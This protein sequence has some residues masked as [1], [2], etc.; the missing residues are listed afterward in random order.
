MHNIDI[1]D[2]NCL[3]RTLCNCH[4]ILYLGITVTK[5][6]CEENYAGDF[7][8][9]MIPDICTVEICYDQSTCNS[10]VSVGENP[11]GPC[12]SGFAGDGKTCSGEC[13]FMYT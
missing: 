4:K 7:C 1:L 6:K 10:T 5:C 2:S 13:N 8:E 3:G 11:C 12:P 9:T